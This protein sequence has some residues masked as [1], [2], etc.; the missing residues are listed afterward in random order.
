[1]ENFKEFELYN[2]NKEESIDTEDK[3]NREEKE[4][5]EVKKV[6]R[7]KFRLM[8]LL[9]KIHNIIIYIRRLPS[10]TKEFLKHTKRQVL[11]SNKT[12]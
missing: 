4:N 5:K 2:D 10:H 3:E 7:V 6:K 9:G 8:G 1:M 11:F 12:R